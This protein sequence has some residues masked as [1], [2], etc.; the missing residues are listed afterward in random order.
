MCLTDLLR[1]FRRSKTEDDRTVSTNKI[2]DA[3]L[4]NTHANE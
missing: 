2:T 4:S 3:A 1:S